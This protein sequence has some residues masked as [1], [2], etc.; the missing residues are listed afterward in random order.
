M[1]MSRFGQSAREIFANRTKPRGIKIYKKKLNSKVLYGGSVNSKISRDYIKIGFDG[2]LVGGASLK[3]EE[4]IKII[5]N[6]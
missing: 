4:F 2:L 6:V 3:A 1:P 5:K